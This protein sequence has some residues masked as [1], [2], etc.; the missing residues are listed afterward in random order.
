MHGAWTYDS[1]EFTQALLDHFHKAIKRALMKYTLF[2]GGPFSQWFDVDFE[3][4]SVKYVNAEQ[5]MMAGKA[6]LF[7]D[8]E[9][10]AL[11]MKAHHP[12]EHKRLGRQV[13]NFD[14]DKWDATSRDVVYEG[15]YAKF[16]QNPELLQALMETQGTTLVEASPTD[17]LWGIGL[18]E[19]DEKAQDKANWRGV[20]WL[21]EVLTKVRDDLA[22]GVKTTKD[23]GWSEERHI[24]NKP[25]PV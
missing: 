21:G 14:P 13:K 4:D 17:L 18:S 24:Y 23:F 5:Y 10:L 8:T 25:P 1:P 3:V 6:K 19:W 15:N 2:Y 16:S 7:G 11:I 12:R 9:T 22:K 20:N